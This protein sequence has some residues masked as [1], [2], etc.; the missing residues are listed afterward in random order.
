VTIRWWDEGNDPLVLLGF[1]KEDQVSN[2]QITLGIQ[3]VWFS[4]TPPPS[5]ATSLSALIYTAG[6]CCRF[7]ISSLYSPFKCKIAAWYSS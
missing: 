2:F 1:V 6:I 5:R 3:N 4:T 7:S